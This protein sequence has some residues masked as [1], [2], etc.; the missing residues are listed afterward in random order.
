M[1][2]TCKNCD[3]QF[4]GNFCNNCGQ[5][6]HTHTI[7]WHYVGHDIQHGILH[8]DKGILYTLKE[9]LLRP[10]VTIRNFLA[11]KRVNYFKPTA[12]LFLLATFYG[13]LYH[14]FDIHISTVYIDEG[15]K[16]YILQK[17][18]E[19]WMA[20]HY[21]LIMLASIPFSALASRLAFFKSGYNYVEHLVINM[22]AASMKMGAL[23]VM[24]PLL[25]AAQKNDLIQYY[26]PIY[27]IM[28]LALLAW[29]FLGV[30]NMYGITSRIVRSVL[31]Y[32]IL[33]F[34]IVTIGVIVGAVV[35]IV[36][37]AGNAH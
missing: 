9:L 33:M 8:V 23:I 16:E 7:N 35:V 28:D 11:G 1:E 21:S 13:F 19:A 5:S 25:Y 15:T 34:F 17:K 22:Y 26:L 29:V 24:F 36:N 3:E 12:M 14:Y 27:Y 20:S 37:M 2:T 18:M 31:S 30:F 4:V 6:A 10:G 32:F